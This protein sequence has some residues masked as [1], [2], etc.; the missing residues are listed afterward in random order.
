M[1]NYSKEQMEYKEAVKEY[2]QV[3]KKIEVE[4]EAFGVNKLIDNTRESRRERMNLIS[5]IENKLGK[6]KVYENLLKV[7]KSLIEWAY[8][9]TIKFTTDQNEINELKKLHDN[10]D[11]L[12]T[13]RDKMIDV[14]MKLK[15][16]GSLS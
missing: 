1:R 7:E 10:Y 15:L 16:T 4:K 9:N 5:T 3:L 6:W 8:E 2:D 14:A 11:K 13:V 12:P